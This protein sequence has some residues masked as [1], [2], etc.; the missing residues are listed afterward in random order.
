MPYEDVKPDIYRMRDQLNNGY[1]AMSQLQN[2]DAIQNLLRGRLGGTDP[3]LEQQRQLGLRNINRNATQNRNL[4]SS[5][6][7]DSGLSGALGINL[8]NDV[9]DS[10]NAAVGGL[11]NM[12][13]QQQRQ[14]QEDAIKNLLGIDTMRAG[15]LESDRQFGMGLNNQ[16]MGID[17]SVE[18]ITTER[19]K[20]KA[21]QDAAKWKAIGQLGSSIAGFALGGPLGGL[22]GGMAGGSVAGTG[23]TGLNMG[24]GSFSNAGAS[25]YSTNGFNMGTGANRGLNLSSYGNNRNP[26]GP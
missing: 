13:A 22:L 1:G 15:A 16:L 5:R 26:W 25:G 6:L 18:D 14:Y 2:A 7:A 17:K 8:F 10:Q 9:T 24:T 4:I 19:Q 23:G 21:E 3:L 11:E 12:L 20:I